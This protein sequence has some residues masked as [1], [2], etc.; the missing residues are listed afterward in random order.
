MKNTVAMILNDSRYDRACTF[1]VNCMGTTEAYIR[2]HK[3]MLIRHWGLEEATVYFLNTR[4]VMINI[5]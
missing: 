5:I 1:I 4:E 3:D 2:E